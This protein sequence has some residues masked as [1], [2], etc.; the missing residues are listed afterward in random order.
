[1][2]KVKVALLTTLLLGLFILI[3]SL[4][5]FIIKKKQKIVDFS[6]GFAFGIMIMLIISDL[7]PEIIAVL[8]L[9]YIFIFIIFTFL[10][11]IILKLLDNFIPDHDDNKMTSTELKG[12]L[13]HIGIVISLALVLHNIIEGMVVYSTIVNKTELGLILTL[14][15]GFHN[16]PLGM[17][18]ASSFYQVSENRYKTMLIIFL[19][20]LSSF[21][22][23][24]IMFF[25][26]VTVLNT[27]FLGILLSITLGM[28]IYISVDE[29]LPR[30]RKS[31]NKRESYIGITFGLIILLIAFF[32]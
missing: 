22:G 23:G 15:V 31:K 8:S 26:G 3:G 2:D 10:G 1:M 12:N 30:I 25:T 17:I 4:I 27:L 5:A 13:I 21:L 18:V 14:G 24:M 11:F 19:I 32:L 6:I 16:I 28:L 20:S 29:L 9:K 7:V